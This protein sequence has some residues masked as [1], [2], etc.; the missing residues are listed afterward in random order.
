L[1]TNP[2]KGVHNLENLLASI[3]VARLMG[4]GRE[5]VESSIADFKGLP[6]RMETVGRIG[7]VEFINDSKATN[8]D[9]T[10][11]SIKSVESNLILVLG[12]KDKG[13]DFNTLK[14]V[15]RERVE[16]VFLIGESARIIF[17]Q[18]NP[19]NNKFEFIEDFREVVEKG[20]DILKGKGGVILLAPGC[21]S[22]DMFNDFEHRGQV[23]REAVDT[24]NKRLGNG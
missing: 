9:A 11:K 21:A 8:V 17:E 6:H 5:A 12:G 14:P 4:I 7:N 20:Y 24:L 3:V 19:L 18:L 13:G 2:L 15:L 22:F 1:A 23:F 16:K 10:L